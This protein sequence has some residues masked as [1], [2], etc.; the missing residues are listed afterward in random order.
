M[1]AVIVN[2]P[3]S[4]RT[5]RRRLIALLAPVLELSEERIEALGAP[6]GF[7]TI[8]ASLSEEEGAFL[9]ARLRALGLP[10]ELTEERALELATRPVAALSAPVPSVALFGEEE[11][12]AL[13]PVRLAKLRSEP[14]DVMRATIPALRSKREQSEAS[15]WGAL[16]PDL[17]IAEEESPPALP[18]LSA[19]PAALDFGAEALSR[20]RP[21][22]VERPAAASAPT[23]SPPEE[24]E[25]PAAAPSFQGGQILSAL[26]FDA[27]EQAPPYAP[28]GYDPRAPHSI[29][30]AVLLSWLAPGAGQVYNGEEQRA[31]E[32]GLRFWL[33]KPWV[34]GAEQARR[35]AEKIAS[36]WAPRPPQDHITRTLRYMAAW[37]LG[38]GAT[39][40]A[41]IAI[42][43]LSWGA[44]RRPEVSAT[45]STKELSVVLGEARIQTQRARIAALDEVGRRFESWQIE[46]AQMSDEER[47]S[48]LFLRGLEACRGNRFSECEQTMRRVVELSGGAHRDALRLQTWA[49]MRRRG[50]LS[51]PMPE[52]DTEVLS[53]SEY[54][55]RQRAEALKKTSPEPAATRPE[56]EDDDEDLFA[57][58]PEEEVP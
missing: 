25:S 14:E 5:E 38:L 15:G 24:L 37:Y 2:L 44:L 45:A 33:F 11:A 20:P 40:A 26:G 4:D 36:F 7:V 13:P 53:F 23:F 58:P 18:P 46:R 39:L 17:E 41:L 3:R 30:I 56:D 32:Y 31:L 50:G 54:E 35:R 29:K 8:E 12:Q 19:P 16:F 43:A 55:R 57:L 49:L 51:V 21:P 47:A 9:L 48:R 42:I 52:L 1:Y 28:Q 6:R 22:L 27:E 10:A 34:E